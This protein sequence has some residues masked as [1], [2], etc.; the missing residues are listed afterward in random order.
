MMANSSPIATA[1]RRVNI[2]AGLPPAPQTK[3]YRGHTAKSFVLI[4]GGAA[5]VL[6][7]LP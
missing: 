6:N 4:D 1:R 3:A 5:I 2:E 7:A